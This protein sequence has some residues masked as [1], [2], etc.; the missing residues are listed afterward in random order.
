MLPPFS[1]STFIHVYLQQLW[2][3]DSEAKNYLLTRPF[4]ISSPENN[5]SL[6]VVYGL[7]WLQKQ[8]YPW[9]TEAQ[10]TFHCDLW[11]QE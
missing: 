2:T 11:Q 9:A 5:F 3:R 4:H 10:A 1:A 8:A 7:V 6:V